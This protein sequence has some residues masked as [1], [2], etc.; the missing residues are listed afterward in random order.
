M[1][2][3]A[4]TPPHNANIVVIPAIMS[5]IAMLIDL[6]ALEFLSLV[7]LAHPLYDK[8]I[9]IGY[10]IL[11]QKARIIM[12]TCK[13]I[14]LSSI[15]SIP[16]IILY[17]SL[18]VTVHEHFHVIALK[19]SAK[20]LGYALK[21]KD[22]HIDYAHCL[23]IPRAHGKTLCHMYA[24]FE[25]NS[26]L[27]NIQSHIK[28]NSKFGFIGDVIFHLIVTLL[29]VIAI[30]IYQIDY[31]LPFIVFLI[32]SQI[33]FCCTA[34]IFFK[35]SDDYTNYKHPEQFKYDPNFKK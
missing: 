6:Y 31:K 17:L 32:L 2:R 16:F 3:K 35:K 5:G 12:V 29:L 21:R 9:N 23:I 20:K 33:L 4:Q 11:Q 28:L 19:Y 24:Y 15:F 27:P 30:Y 8:V 18:S 34:I 7:F 22:I 25:N 10:T 14:L 26:H 1:I 13:S